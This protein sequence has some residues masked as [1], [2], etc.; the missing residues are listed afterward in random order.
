M[1][2]SIIINTIIHMFIRKKEKEKTANIE[3]QNK[4]EQFADGDNRKKS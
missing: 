3:M 4:I 1:E 2:S